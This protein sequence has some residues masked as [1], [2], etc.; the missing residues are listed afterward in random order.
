MDQGTVQVS[1]TLVWEGHRARQVEA[2][3]VGDDV[4]LAN[5]RGPRGSGDGVEGEGAH[6]RDAVAVGGDHQT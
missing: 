6:Q 1:L 3:L 5:Q 2:W 4:H